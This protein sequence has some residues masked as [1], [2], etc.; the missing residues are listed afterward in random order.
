MGIHKSSYAH[1]VEEF[2]KA[3]P[4]ETFGMERLTGELGLG[5]DQI[6]SA[7]AYLRGKAKYGVNDT[8]DIAVVQRG[9]LWRYSA[10]TGDTG[11][12]KAR[13]ARREAERRR[14]EA[15]QGPT[16]ILNEVPQRLR[17][18][19]DAAKIAANI[20]KMSLPDWAEAEQALQ[21][22]QTHAVIRLTL[23]GTTTE[24]YHIGKDEDSG[25][26]FKVVPL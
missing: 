16:K 9:K 19:E 21:R 13:E 8:I 26:V 1:Q 11:A 12:R 15:A 6:R 4:N 25:N 5:S 23:V 18:S 22:D 14:K 2:F 24:G 17:I 3:N 10:P 20:A 7:L